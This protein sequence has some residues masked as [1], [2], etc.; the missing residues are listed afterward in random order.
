MTSMT[1]VWKIHMERVIFR[2]SLDFFLC[3]FNLLTHPIWMNVWHGQWKG[4]EAMT[5]LDELSYN[6]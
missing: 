1:T 5:R 4:L 6:E 3:R 2:D